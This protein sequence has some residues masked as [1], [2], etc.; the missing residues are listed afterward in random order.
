MRNE[1]NRKLQ[2]TQISR[3]ILKGLKTGNFRKAS[4]KLVKVGAALTQTEI[5]PN[6]QTLLMNSMSP[7]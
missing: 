4:V 1:S 2:L 6:R 7:T 3:I 5:S